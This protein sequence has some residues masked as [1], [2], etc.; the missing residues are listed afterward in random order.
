MTWKQLQVGAAAVEIG[1]KGGARLVGAC[2]ER[3][4]AVLPYLTCHVL[5]H[6]IQQQAGIQLVSQAQ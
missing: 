1:E 6:S 3:L 2:G 5:D 4:L